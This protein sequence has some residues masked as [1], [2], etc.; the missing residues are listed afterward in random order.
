MQRA[1]AF[2]RLERAIENRQVLRL[3]SGRNPGAVGIDY[4]FNR[5]ECV[6]MRND[7]LDLFGAV[8]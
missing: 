2:E 1:L 7:A 5:V 4:I 6:D 3:Q 8:T